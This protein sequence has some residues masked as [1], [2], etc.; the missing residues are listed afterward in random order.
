MTHK[1]AALLLEG[2]NLFEISIAHEVFGLRRPE[3]GPTPLY[4]LTLCSKS[5]QAQL[6]SGLSVTTPGDLNSVVDADTVIVPFGLP[7]G[8]AD[9]ELIQALLEAHRRGARLASFC[10]G[11]FTLAETGLLDGRRATTHWRY[12]NDFRRRFPRV[13]FDPNVLYVDEGDV[14]TSAGS[15]AGIDLA[16]HLVRMDYGADVSAAVARRMV[17]PPP[18][19]G[20]QAQFID[21]PHEPRVTSDG[22]GR[23]LDWILSQLHRDISVDELASM[24]AMS[25]RTFA[26]RFK[27]ATGTTPLRWIQ[28]QRLHRAQQLLETTDLDM[29]QVASRSGFGSGTNLRVHFRRE[30]HT[31]PS[32]YRR[33]FRAA[34]FPDPTAVVRPL[35]R[36]QSHPIMDGGATSPLASGL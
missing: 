16:L 32:R 30:L 7:A 18:R 14:L 24:A 8:A 35:S 21:P 19:E 22:L 2:A 10:S 15:A 1:V 23:V 6:N 5:G 9:P 26:R 33:A 20:G 34:R 13:A 4:E 12:A 27:E 17:V 29:E 3:L 25:R 11:A 31:T 28:M 36:Q